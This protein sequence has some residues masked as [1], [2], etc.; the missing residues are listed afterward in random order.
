M[1]LAQ[2]SRVPRE[3]SEPKPV[4]V[5]FGLGPNVTSSRGHGQSYYFL[6]LPALS[7]VQ[8]DST[9]CK[10]SPH[11]SHK[12]ELLSPRPVGLGEFPLAPSPPLHERR[13]SIA[14]AAFLLNAREH[15]CSPRLSP[16]RNLAN[17]WAT[18]HPKLSVLSISTPPSKPLALAQIP[19]PY[20]NVSFSHSPRDFSLALG[21]LPARGQ[22]EPILVTRRHFPKMETAR[23]P[24]SATTLDR[25]LIRG[26][27]MHDRRFT[28]MQALG[29]PILS[30]LPPSPR[31]FSP[32]ARRHGGQRPQRARQAQKSAR[33]SQTPFSVFFLSRC[34]PEK[35]QK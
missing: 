25:P 18:P 13:V 17:L 28:Y 32:P 22:T 8:E 30:S 12:Q 9:A 27:E 10:Q 26:H 20:S 29:P 31:L 11:G 7:S 1:G 3:R 23:F 34:A 15:R 33:Q 16:R 6:S 35:G 2:K 4:R 19:L 14:S 24:L 21:L 5:T